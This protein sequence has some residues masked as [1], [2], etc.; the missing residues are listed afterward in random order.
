MKGFWPVFRKELYGMFMS[1]IF[2]AVGF[3]F[4]LVSG[5]FFNYILA[6]VVM[7]SFQV[8]QH[9]ELVREMSMMD[10]LLRSFLWNLSI[11][12]LFIA[13]LL[14]MRLY[15]EER[16]SG[17]IELLFTYPVT[18]AAAVA[19]K[20]AA[21]LTAFTILIAATLPGVI[22]VA[23][24][25]TPAWK[26]I[27]SGYAGVFLLGC[28]F[29]SLGTFA[30]TLTRNQIISAVITFGVLLVLWFIGEAKTWVGPTAGSILE[31]LSVSK[32][33]EGLSKGLIDSRDILFFLVFSVFFLFLT[34]RQMSSYRWRG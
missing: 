30:S 23:S 20:F 26:L 22:A 1:P 10:L 17:T 24:L 16:K 31:Y 7:V 12:M 5:V 14:T 11:V 21:C 25:S 28:A 6:Q 27:F 15:A 13:P 8:A 19:G 29:L 2:Y 18:D 33:F 32:H 9:P 3:I 34:L 4:L